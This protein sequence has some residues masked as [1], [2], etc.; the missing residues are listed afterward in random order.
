M[1]DGRNQG[2]ILTRAAAHATVFALRR[3]S[4]ARDFVMKEDFLDA[5]AGSSHNLQPTKSCSRKLRKEV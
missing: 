4:Y 1:H 2:V 5:A 3:G